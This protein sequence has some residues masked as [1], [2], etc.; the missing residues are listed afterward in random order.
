MTPVLD[1]IA[2]AWADSRHFTSARPRVSCREWF[3]GACAGRL[4]Y[5]A[6]SAGRP[7]PRLLRHR[8]FG[9]LVYVLRNTELRRILC[10]VL[11]Y[12]FA[13]RFARQHFR[14]PKVLRRQPPKAIYLAGT[15][16]DWPLNE[17]IR[18]ETN[19]P[20]AR[21]QLTHLSTV[22]LRFACCH[23]CSLD[24]KVRSA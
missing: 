17:L 11:R 8:V 9:P 22:S 15:L 23:I 1:C 19:V 16:P 7:A 21:L 4:A 12:S 20:I 24:V 14:F 6:P 5:S 3:S 10:R 18:T 2:P 13:L